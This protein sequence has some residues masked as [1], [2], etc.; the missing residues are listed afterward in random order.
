MRFLWLSVILNLC[1]LVKASVLSADDVI[2]YRDEDGIIKVTEENYQ[3]LGKGLREFYSAVFITSDSPNQH[4]ELCDLCGEFEPNFRIVSKSMVKQLSK[5]Q[6]D[7]IMFF[8]VDLAENPSF[9]K[10][11]QVTKIPFCLIYP[12]QPEL[13]KEGQDFGWGHSP[14]YQ[15]VIKHDNMKQATHFADFLAKILNVFLTIEQRFEYDKFAQVFVVCVMVFVF[16]KKKVLPLITNKPKFFLGLASI[17]IIMISVS[18]YNFTAMNHVPFIAQNKEGHVMWFSGGSHYQ[19]GIEVLTISSFYTVLGG[20]FLAVY[21][22]PKSVRLGSVEKSVISAVI[23]VILFFIYMYFLSIIDIKYPG[24][25][26]G[27]F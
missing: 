4:G 7:R 24:Y 23:A 2:E 18:G 11:F 12:P 5:E 9:L 20:L 13:T 6:S 22:V 8:K 19:F 21:F 25:P 16:F 27:I 17:A 3:F 26:Y 15:Y 14:F 10:D 1:L